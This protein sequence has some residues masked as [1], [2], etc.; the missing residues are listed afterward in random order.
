MAAVVHSVPTQL[1][2][3]VILHDPNRGPNSTVL[4]ISLM[5]AGIRRRS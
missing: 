4:A 5:H 2:D 3:L 1:N